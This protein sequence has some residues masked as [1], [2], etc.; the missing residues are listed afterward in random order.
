MPTALLAGAFGQRNPGDDALL[1]AFTAALDGWEVCATSSGWPAGPAGAATV[2]SFERAAVARRVAAAD[3]VVFAGGTVFKPL[4][5]ASRR[6]PLDLLS[7]AVALGMGA[8]ALGKPLALVGVGAAPLRGR[9]ARMLARRLVHQADLLVL[10]DD[11]SAALLAEAGAPVPFRV[12]SDAAWTLLETPPVERPPSPDGPVIVALSHD[13]GDGELAEW[14]T[15]ALVPVL[16]SG[17]EVVLQ[18]WQIGRMGSR[19]DLD[20]AHE[21]Q[22]RLGGAVSL[23]VPPRDLRLAREAFAGASVVVGLRFH[24]LVA[25][26][27]AGVPFVAYAHEP[28]LEGLARRM[29]Q[30]ALGADAAP[31]SLGAAIIA[32]ARA[33]APAAGAAVRHEIA[34]AEEG[35]R[36]LRLLL[37]GG[38][39]EDAETLGALPLEPAGWHG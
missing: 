37:N 18:P 32:A 4:R 1:E 15:A 25:A 30:P 34:A 12:G 6:A 36:L 19:D 10:R 9:R 24:A 17:L 31:E 28:K 38:R 5:P 35:F 7:R 23:S 21:L 27:S 13:A 11:D 33:Q 3:A 16:A 22:A 20:L 29:R 39:P 14:L 8:K 2:H 26:A